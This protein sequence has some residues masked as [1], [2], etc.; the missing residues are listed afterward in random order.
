M[1]PS[2]W[3]DRPRNDRKSFRSIEN[4]CCNLTEGPRP[5]AGYQVYF[6]SFDSSFFTVPAPYT[7]K[8]V[9]RPNSDLAIQWIDTLDPSPALQQFA[10][11][12]YLTLAS[13]LQVRDDPVSV[14]TSAQWRII[15]ISNTMEVQNK[16]ISTIIS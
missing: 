12:S 9:A 2:R 3:P 13:T 1:Q 4:P 6:A 7:T 8:P 10:V 15:V 5:T 16:T 11:G 14:S